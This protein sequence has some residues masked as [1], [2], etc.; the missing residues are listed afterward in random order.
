[1]AHAQGRKT[2]LQIDQ[3]PDQKYRHQT[4]NE[5]DL[6]GGIVGAQQPDDD[7]LN[8]ED[9]DAC[10]DQEYALDWGVDETGHGLPYIGIESRDHG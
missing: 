6:Q 9:G 1:M 4:A 3:R 5:H 10:G 8:A 7:V 2:A